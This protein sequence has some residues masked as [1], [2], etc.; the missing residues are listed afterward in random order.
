MKK[1]FKKISFGVAF[2]VLMICMLCFGASAL[3]SSGQCGDNVYWS[4]NSDTG[5]LVISGE[6][7]M[8]DYYAGTSPF[9]EESAIRTIVIK[10]GVT[11]I[12]DY[13][14]VG[15]SYLTSI[16]IPD[17]VTCIGANALTHSY[18]LKSIT[19]PDS[20]K[21]IKRYA[22]Y[23]SD[24]R[25]TIY[26]SSQLCNIG[27]HAFSGAKLSGF[28]VDEENEFYSSEDGVLFNKDKSVLIQYPSYN[29]NTTYIV[30]D[31]VEVLEIGAFS[32][33]ENIKEI[34]IPYSV[35]LIDGQNF[36]KC[37]SLEDV[38]YNGT[39]REW[40][41]IEITTFND[42]LLN[43]NIHFHTHI[44]EDNDYYC[45][46]CGR[47]FHEFITKTENATCTVNGYSMTVCSVCGCIANSEIISATGHTLS[48]WTEYVKATCTED[49]ENRKYCQNC[50]Y[51]ESETIS[52]T[53]HTLSDW[54]EY[55]K[56][57]CT[58]DGENRKNCQKCDYYES[59]IIAATGHEW[60]EWTLTREPSLLETGI[61]TS[62]CAV[63]GEKQTRELPQKKSDASAKDDN[64]GINVDYTNE[65]YE[66]DVEVV[67]VPDYDGSQ[68][69]TLPLEDYT[70]IASWNIKIYVND[71]EVQPAEPV[72]VSIPL[73]E[74]FN[75]KY[76]AVYHIDSQTGEFER[77]N[78]VYVEDGYVRF[79][80]DS[81]SVYTVVDESSEKKDGIEAL[82][83]W[84]TN[85][86]GMFTEFITK[87]FSFS[88]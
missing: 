58:E 15:C 46:D 39:E 48:D 78:P 51:Y 25:G 57:T 14:F 8:E 52:S 30:P 81:F 4:F 76:I 62:V 9:S 10:K 27:E 50:D 55:K 60:G 22:F 49:G 13:S 44:D 72:L 3:E 5:E 23:N 86:I 82:F 88:C 16:I 68:Y 64:T 34:Y 43:A 41:K 29:S 80:A 28:D 37:D 73:P 31:T 79:L 33:S 77:I 54:T 38:Y 70:K 26:I 20:V 36:W 65:A 42:D 83:E 19:I 40:N 11:S 69:V 84:L 75:S 2:V 71:E 53:G 24:I 66:G 12:G 21:E 85:L 1:K 56:A 45:D 67:V 61:E 7:K 18:G 6:G 59:E 47:F 74:G 35:V 32:R 17:S 63:C 87:L